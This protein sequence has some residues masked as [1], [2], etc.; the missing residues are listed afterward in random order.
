[1]ATTSADLCLKRGDTWAG[2]FKWTTASD[3]APWNL[4]GC[5]ARLQVRLPV[6]APVAYVR[7]QVQAPGARDYGAPVFDLS[8]DPAGG[9][10]IDGE[11]GYVYI[12]V[13][14]AETEALEVRSD[15]ALDQQ[16]TFPDGTVV[17][18]A[19]LIMEVVEDVTHD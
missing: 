9:L 2:V 7:S 15:Y 12:R 14:A 18:T 17:S 3:G 5:T 10:T 1:M 19:T 16:L 8:T 11:L 6:D 4:T 13:E